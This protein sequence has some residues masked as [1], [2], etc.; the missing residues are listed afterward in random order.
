[1]PSL[2]AAVVTAVNWVRTATSPT[3]V[4][5]L[6][7]CQG[8]Q[9]NTGYVFYWQLPTVFLCNTGIL[10]ASAISRYHSALDHTHRQCCC[11]GLEVQGQGHYV[12]GQ[13]QGLKQRKGHQCLQCKFTTHKYV[14]F[15]DLDTIPHTRIHKAVVMK[16]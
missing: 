7:A 5:T 2:P 15:N 8:S 6:S 9:L 14:L 11:Q 3:G 10:H 12:R 1:M 4:M 16:T 13:G